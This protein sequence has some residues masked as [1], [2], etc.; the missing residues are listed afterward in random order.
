MAGL[1]QTILDDIPVSFWTFDF[2]VEGLNNDQIIDEVGN[3]N[4]MICQNDVN[5][6]N[7]E[8]EQQGL[9][10]LEPQDQYAVAIARDQNLNGFWLEQYFEVVDSSS[11][12][13]P[14]LGQFSIEFLYHKAPPDI[15]R[16]PG[17]PGHN[18][19]IRTPI[20]RK[21]GLVQIGIEDNIYTGDRLVADVHGHE[22]I[23]DN[24]LYPLFNRSNHVVVTY[25]VEQ[26]DVNEYQATAQLWV[27]GRLWDSSTETHIDVYPD[28][29]NTS[30]WLFAGNGG[31]NPNTDFATEL[32]KLDQIAVYEF[33]LSEQ[34]IANHYR[35]TKLYDTMIEHDQVYRYWKLDESTYVNDTLS[36][37][38]GGVHGKYYGSVNK[39]QPGPDRL[40]GHVAPYFNNGAAAYIRGYDGNDQFTPIL[41]TSGSFSLEI[42]FKS[43]DSAQGMLFDFSQEEPN[44][45][46]LRVY[47]NSKNYNHYTGNIQ[48]TH[49]PTQYINS[50]DYDDN[51]N[52]YLFNDNE[53]HYVVCR[54]SDTSN[55][56]ELYIDNIKHGELETVI[57]S[58]DDP[59]AL[60]LMNSRPGDQP[61]D[62]SIC[63]VAFYKYALQD[64]QIYNRW[65][66]LTRYKVQGYT[67]LQGVP[68]QARVRFYDTFAGHLLREVQS[69]SLTGEFSY[70][71][72]TNKFVDILSQLPD[73]NTTR[74]RVH[75][76]VKPAEY[77]DTHLIS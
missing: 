54:Y 59:G 6:K 18:S 64:W 45:N 69:D 52:R 58:T 51:E 32:L 61:I 31:P 53:W 22:L 38:V 50:L 3:A 26:T 13:F 34:Q 20:A 8:L 7:Y 44:W 25:K 48:V 42:W 10:E 47:I 74:Y 66:F 35:K 46:G 63:N 70:Y 60:T 57:N 41:T 71:P 62:G 40:A 16:Q 15:I 23:I 56:L 4:P 14:D 76:P 12:D 9:N 29:N 72:Q 37:L 17:E 68:V 24:S 73:V 36:A 49:S 2:D 67:Y 11:Y 30:S 75:G 77:D 39:A 55:L 5:G 28:S 19:D 43:P 27:N 21:G 1:K 33:A 65:N